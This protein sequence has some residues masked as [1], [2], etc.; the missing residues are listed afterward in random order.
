MAPLPPFDRFPI[1]VRIAALI[2]LAFLGLS[3]VVGVVEYVQ[4]GNAMKRDIDRQLFEAVT[5][6]RLPLLDDVSER[7]EVS[8]EDS[9]LFGARGGMQLIDRFGRVIGAAG[10]LAGI[11]RLITID[12]MSDIRDGEQLLTTVR[13]PDTGED[14]RVLAVVLDIDDPPQIELEDAANEPEDLVAVVGASLAPVDEAQRALLGVYGTSILLGAALAGL[15]GLVIARR[16]LAPIAQLTRDA[17][18][19]K[20]SDL[21]GRLSEPA[22]MDEVGRLARTLNDLLAR[23]SSAV[24]R[25]RSFTADASHELRT[26]LAILRTEL[27]LALEKARDREMRAALESALEEC[28]RLSRLVEDLLVLARTE[29]ATLRLRPVDLGELAR[30]T[31]DRFRRMADQRGIRLEV[32]GEA[33]T[34][35]DEQ[36]LE[37]ALSNLVDNSVRHTPAGGRVTVAVEPV[38]GGATIQVEDTG[39]GVADDEL[40]RLFD[41]FYR[42]DGSRAGGGAGLGLAIVASVAERHGGGVSANNAPGGG[43]VISLRIP[44]RVAPTPAPGAPSSL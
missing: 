20:A 37:R 44:D 14:L 24:E 36:A 29:S 9:E 8:E 2:A 26:P 3:A 41:R 18:A 40:D 6:L 4:T 5:S 31:T 30:A 15:L 25:E 32:K 27:D 39:P 7:G 1:S 35:C 42:P 10:Q 34:V 13:H 17:D 19:F 43:F 33:V 28:D 11:E 38:P 12:Q 23:L 16:A 21:Q 22:R